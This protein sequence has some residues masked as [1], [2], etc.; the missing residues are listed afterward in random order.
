MRRSVACLVSVLVVLGAASPAIADIG[1]NRPPGADATVWQSY[2]DGYRDAP[3]WS[4]RGTIVADTRFRSHP[5]GFSFFNTGV[6]DVFNNAMFGSPLAGPKNLDAEAM[7]SLMGRKVCAEKRDTGPCTLTLAAQQWMDSAN[8]SMAGGHCFGFASAA[9]ELFGGM[10][11]PGQ[12]QPGVTRTYDLALR[13]PISRQIARNMAAQYAMDVLDYRTSPRQSV[14]LLKR[15]LTPG[16]VPYTLFILWEGGGHALTPYAVFDRG[17]GKYDIGVYD[18]N[19]PDAERA[20][21]VDTRANTYEY[22]VMTNPNGSP[23]IADDIIGLVPTSVIAGRQKCPFCPGANETTVQLKPV[24]SK[25]RIRTRLTDLDGKKIKGATVKK[26]TN[27]WRPGERWEFPTY[28][29]PKKQDFIVTIDARRSK[30]PV[31]TNLLAVTGQFAVGTQGATIPARG[32]GAV[33][34]VPERGLIVYGV[35]EGGDLGA[36]T[37]VDSRPTVQVEVRASTQSAG[38]PFLLGQ[39]NERSKKVVLFTPDGRKGS[40]RAAAALLFV[41]SDGVPVEVRARAAAVLPRKAR[42]VIDYAAWGPK[43]R[44]GVSAYVKARGR[45]TPVDVTFTRVGR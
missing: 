7:R 6:P 4:P 45:R 29:V 17:E 44:S 28:V 18:N 21:R 32:A 27:P 37:F 22:L 14:E 35:N 5:D 30:V 8:E 40:A 23:E 43:D 2:V 10:L 41:G 26:P 20:I 16:S 13:A 9:A 11:T 12:F 38:G 34:L 42:L 24:K 15:S 36:L 31:R 19:Y 1:D 39:L 33:G 25:V 3:D